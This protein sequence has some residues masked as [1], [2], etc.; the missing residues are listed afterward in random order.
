MRDTGHCAHECNLCYSTFP[1][2]AEQAHH[3]KYSH[4]YC[5]DCD[6][7]FQSLNNLEMHLKSRI[8]LGTNIVCPFCAAQYTTASGLTHHL[9]R[10]SCPNAPQ[11]D[12]DTLYKFVRSKD[13]AGTISKKLLGW[14]GTSDT[15]EAT[16]R[17]WNGRCYECYFC[18]Q[19]FS[20]LQSLN[21]HLASPAHQQALYHCF[22]ISCRREFTTLGALIS[23]LESER[24]GATRFENVQRGIDDFIRKGRLLT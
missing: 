23:H 24:C 1:T 11:M 20:A 3:E 21:Q 9:E 15:Y 8:H 18:H 4:Y 5:E 12:R 22:N 17:A 19:G 10:G 7:T 16:D 13:S 14:N 2:A 6:R